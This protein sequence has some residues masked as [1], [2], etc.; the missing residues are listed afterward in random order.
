M[1]VENIVRVNRET[2]NEPRQQFCSSDT[3]KNHA[4]IFSG[5]LVEIGLQIRVGHAPIFV[6]AHRCASDAHQ[7]RMN[8]ITNE[9]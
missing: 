2:F 4:K 1:A 9:K 8:R 7:M 3:L 6:D 5:I